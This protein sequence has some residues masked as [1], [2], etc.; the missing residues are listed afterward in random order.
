MASASACTTTTRR[1]RDSTSHGDRRAR[2]SSSPRAS[3][4]G[5]HAS[6]GWSRPFRSHHRR[7]SMRSTRSVTH[8]AL[9]IAA[10]SLVQ[11]AGAVR[12][13]HSPA[14][15]SIDALWVQPDHIGGQ[16]LFYGPWGVANAPDPNA[17]YTFLRPKLTGTNP[18]L[19]VRDPQGREW[20][21]KQPSLDQRRGDEGPSEVV[22]SRVLSALGYHQPPVY[23]L[24]TFMLRDDN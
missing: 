7:V 14:A 20:H 12:A 9:I 8:V 17:E 6:A 5:C 23:Y 19:V 11:C 2:T 3:P 10:V 24:P 1:S 13:T 21:V 4:S 18:G 22:L 15:P 16:D